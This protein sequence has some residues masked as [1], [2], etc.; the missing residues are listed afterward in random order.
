MNQ[1]PAEQDSSRQWARTT[2]SSSGCRLVDDAVDEYVLGIADPAQAAAIERHLLRCLRCTELVTSFDLTV[3]AL[4]LAV[5]LVSPPASTRAA[6]RSRVAATPQ[7]APIPATVAVGDLA[8]FRTA[9]LPASNASALPLPPAAQSQTAWWRAYAAPLATLPLLLA[10]GLVSAWGFNNLAKLNS[11]ENTIAMQDQQIASMND[12][13]NLDEQQVM[14]L[15]FS[16]SSKRYNMSSDAS[17]SGTP[18][19][20]T[21]LT[22]PATG[23]AA[24]QVEGLAPGSYSVLVQL[25]DGTMVRKATFLVGDDGTASTP[26]DLGEQVTDFQ[27]IHIRLNSYVETDMAIDGDAIDVLMAVI[28]PN[29][30]QSSG[31]G[32]Q[33]Q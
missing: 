25:D 15:A 33:G 13:Y 12:Q 20:G 32:L 4:A 21:L 11:A 14:Q 16:P 30:N 9:T 8:A 31:T 3:T 19:N 23:Q 18:M 27:S 1:H 7:Q 2:T 22:D 10:L 5:P 29:I 17:G 28:G 26:V 6:T 24:L